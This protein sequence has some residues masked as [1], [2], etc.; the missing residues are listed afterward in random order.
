MTVVTG[1]HD[2]LFGRSQATARASL[3]PSCPTRGDLP[4][5]RFSSVFGYFTRADSCITYIMPHF[6]EVPE[7]SNG[8]DSKSSVRVTVPW[9]RIPPS[10]PDM[11][12]VPSGGQYSHV[13]GRRPPMRLFVIILLVLLAGCARQPLIAYS[14]SEPP[15]VMMPAF[16]AG[17]TDGTVPLQGN[18]VCDQCRPRGAV[19]R[20]P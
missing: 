14:T 8:L 18:M 15:M 9:V 3:V 5:T 6:G 4:N 19:A 2:H 17:I 7:W 1:S 10:P 11:T 16:A 12:V 20:L 13:I